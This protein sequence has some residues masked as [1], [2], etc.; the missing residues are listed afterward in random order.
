MPS[1]KSLVNVDLTWKAVTNANSIESLLGN[2]YALEKE[3]RFAGIFI[4]DGKAATQL[5]KESKRF[6]I[7]RT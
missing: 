2:G 3:R 1:K 6:N 5:T 4:D 7:K